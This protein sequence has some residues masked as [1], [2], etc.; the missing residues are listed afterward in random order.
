MEV[1]VNIQNGIVVKANAGR[2][3]GK[4]FVVVGA[5]NAHILIADGKTRKLA[6][7]K[8]KNVK[9]LTFTEKSVE[10]N[11]ITDKKLRN[12]LRSFSG[13]P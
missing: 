10:L 13:T 11:G 6:S 5:E 8:R 1:R 3:N 7:P 2:D 12:V 9:H 4:Y